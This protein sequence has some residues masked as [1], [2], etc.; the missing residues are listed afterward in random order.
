MID[1]ESAKLFEWRDE[2]RHDM[3]LRQ[4]A[5]LVRARKR[6][7][8]QSLIEKGTQFFGLVNGVI[9]VLANPEV[10]SRKSLQRRTS[11]ARF[12]VLFGGWASAG[13]PRS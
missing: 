2:Q 1:V 9:F 6:Y 5:A 13:N 4:P 11:V 8:P 10:E 7:A 12:D 3:T